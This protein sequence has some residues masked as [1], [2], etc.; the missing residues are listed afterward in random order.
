MNYS[1]LSK[2]TT[3]DTAKAQLA[4]LKRIGAE[5][6]LRMT[7][8]LSDNIRDITISG[9]RKRHPEYSEDMVAKALIKCLHGEAIFKKYFPLDML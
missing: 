5:G 2:D 9:I 4:A 7:I 1:T 8:E 3:I 6:R